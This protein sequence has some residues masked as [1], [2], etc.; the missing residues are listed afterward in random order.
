[1]SDEIKIR[2]FREEDAPGLARMWQ[3][4]LPA[5][6][7]F[8]NDGIPYTAERVLREQREFGRIFMLVAAGEGEVPGFCGISHIPKERSAAYVPILNVSPSHHKQGLGKRLLLE[9]LRRVSDM[10]YERLDL[11][12]WTANLPAVPLYKKTGFFWVPETTVLMV[13][14]LPKIWRNPVAKAYFDKHDWYRTF[15]RELKLEPDVQFLGKAK[16]FINEW[17][18]QGT[19]L[20]VTVDHEAREI[21]AIENPEFSLT[22]SLPEPEPVVGLPHTVSFKVESRTPSPL[23]IALSLSADGDEEFHKETS[24]T[25]VKEEVVEAEMR[26]KPD[27]SPPKDDMPAWAIRATAVVN[28]VPVR[29]GM[30]FR[31][32]QPVE[33]TWLPR[34]VS[35]GKGLTTKVAL[36]L[37]S[38]LD[39]E[40]TASLVILPHSGVELLSS[41]P[42]I[43]VPAKGRAGCVLEL[44]AMEPG[45]HT[46]KISPKVKCGKDTI[47]A[48]PKDLSVAV[49]TSETTL[50]RSDEDEAVLENSCL[51]VDIKLRGSNLTVTH[52]GLGFALAGTGFPNL[53]P[54]LWP[55]EFLDKDFKVSELASNPLPKVLLS[56]E[57]D[58][59]PGITFEQEVTLLS[60]ELVRIVH[61]VHNAGP[62]P[63]ELDVLLAQAAA[64]ERFDLVFPL[65]AGLVIEPSVD[66]E[67]PGRQKDLPDRGEDYLE[68]WWA[69]QG[70][71]WCSGGI[72][73]GTH[74]REYPLI[75]YHLIVP[76]QGSAETEP[77]LVYAGQGNWESVRNHYHQAF[78]GNDPVRLR[79]LEPGP[80]IRLEME[81][82]PLVV[83]QKDFQADLT[84]RNLRRRVVS[85]TLRIVVHDG[86]TVTPAEIKVGETNI[87]KPFTQDLS[88]NSPSTSPE[89]SRGSLAF[90]TPSGI[91]EREFS[92]I[93]L[94]PGAS[95]SVR[96][97]ELKGHKVWR[98]DNG[99]FQ[100]LAS[101]RYSGTLFAWMEGETN[102]LHTAF[103][104][105]GM[106]SWRNPFYGG[107]EPLLS[108]KGEMRRMPLDKE[109]WEAE[110][111][112]RKGK[113]GHLWK[114]VRL[115]TIP[116]HKDYQGLALEMDHLT[117]PGASLLATFIRL[118]N[119]TS[120][121]LHAYFALEGFPDVD[122]SQKQAMLHYNPQGGIRPR[123][124]TG[125][126]HY[127]S[128]WSASMSPGTGRA[129]V[130]V[131]TSP[132]VE[133]VASDVGSHGT[134]HGCYAP[135]DLWP[136]ESKEYLMFWALA[137]DLER[138]R[139][140]ETLSSC[141]DLP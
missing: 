72:W 17:E 69:Q 52:K 100:F 78:T 110:P 128:S 25:V 106:F 97:E 15:K 127:C 38:R 105:P 47:S 66:G 114:G 34:H 11:H 10:G 133:H 53:V 18:E 126:W 84:I 101:P 140:Y 132:K 22:L 93:S 117:L 122:G 20:K 65:K 16:V 123:G 125:A 74:R 46:L 12:T 104:E 141:K 108:L 124:E 1:M 7:P 58:L 6:P 83:S 55:N 19:W 29:L 73:P 129:L 81:P 54:P 112:E 33:T 28:D 131:T 107:L 109:K 13:N 80:V 26:I 41:P 134:F 138:A 121:S 118:R 64:Q 37:Q 95:L 21:C 115:S 113:S 24:F 85:G 96:E 76:A 45:F 98:M 70:K 90:E 8:F 88:F 71:D 2:D 116:K 103:P 130:L 4:S 56:A 136:N 40:A 135:V 5:W 59:R 36:G 75:Y 43:T 61:R 44:K 35:V 32:K 87:E 67:F 111:V 89:I 49:L 60:G 31:P 63:T 9:A 42:D 79:P 48:K 39:S 62:N 99:R 91:R 57:S 82:E 14:Y 23:K 119:L 120:G 27:I 77:L 137:Q 139:L 86:Y 3:E 51:R 68:P 50:S 92:I 94:T 30:G 102:H